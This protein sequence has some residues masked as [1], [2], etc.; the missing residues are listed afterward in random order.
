MT[1]KNVK[2]QQTTIVM[3]I[4]KKMTVLVILLDMKLLV[5]MR[6]TDT[7]TPARPA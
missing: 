2:I 3:E 6:L 5:M 7:R 1:F 4:T